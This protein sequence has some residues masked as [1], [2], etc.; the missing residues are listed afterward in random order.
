[1]LFQERFL[2][3]LLTGALA[4]LLLPATGCGRDEIEFRLHNTGM[5]A[6]HGLVL[7]LG[8]AEEKVGELA[9][10][11]E[12]RVPLPA[13]PGKPLELRW[14]DGS[15]QVRYATQELGP[16]LR[17]GARGVSVRFA[18]GRVLFRRLEP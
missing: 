7:K 5:A 12:V 9:A 3:Y 11:A 17:G 16:M 13:A 15:G 4:A 2:R 10:G 14:Q 6:I 18:A 8:E 1:M